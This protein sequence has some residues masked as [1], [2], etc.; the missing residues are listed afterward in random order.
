MKIVA[1]TNV[2][3]RVIVAD[4]A[5]QSRAA[6]AAMEQADLATASLHVLCEW[7]WVLHRRQEVSR[8]DIAAAIR[9]LAN[10]RNIVLH[11]PAVEAGLSAFDAG[12]DFADCVIAFEGRGLGGEAFAS[13]DQKVVALLTAQG[14]STLML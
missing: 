7:V 1:D 5:K 8:R 3:L 13:C 12:G 10:T 2:L 9:H 14:Q 4:D 11:R 6:L